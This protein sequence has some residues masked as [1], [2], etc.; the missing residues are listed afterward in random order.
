M[1]E[2]QWR[3]WSQIR[4]EAI[5][6]GRIT[7][8]GLA[9]GRARLRAAQRAYRL[10][11]I[12][13]ELGL[14]QREVAASMDVSQRRVS[15]LERGDLHRSELG[16]IEAYVNALGGRVEIVANFGDERVVVGDSDDPDLADATAESSAQPAPTAKLGAKPSPNKAR[17]RKTPA[18]RY[19]VIPSI[20]DEVPDSGRR[21]GRARADK[22]TAGRKDATKST[23]SG[24]KKT[25]AKKT[26]AGK[27]MAKKSTADKGAAKK[28]AKP[29]K[30]A[31]K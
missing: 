29:S 22:S 30:A 2:K 1:T 4:A 6:A 23:S 14:R 10:A 17:K 12:R 11:E 21:S 5:A 31:P 19:N 25:M 8:K 18:Q 13:K 26:T 7:E 15:A 27:G 3:T 9:A 24:T 20:L 28:P 16:T